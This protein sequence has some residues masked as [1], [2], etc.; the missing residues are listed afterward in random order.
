MS[1]PEKQYHRTMA[2]ELKRAPQEAKEELF[3]NN[4]LDYA[5]MVNGLYVDANPIEENKDH[6]IYAM[7]ALMI[8]ELD[9][10]KSTKSL[11][12]LCSF[13]K[14]SPGEIAAKYVE[15]RY[16]PRIIF[17]A[18]ETN[19]MDP[20]IDLAAALLQ[21]P[22]VDTVIEQYHTI[23]A[24]RYPKLEDEVKDYR[25]C[26]NEGNS[27]EGFR[28][29]LK[30]YGFN[31]I[32]DE[33]MEQLLTAVVL[34]GYEAYTSGI[35]LP[36][37][38]L[39][40]SVTTNKKDSMEDRGRSY[41]LICCLY[42]LLDEKEHGSTSHESVKKIAEEC[43]AENC[44]YGNPVATSLM[45]SGAIKENRYD[46][47]AEEIMESL[48]FEKYYKRRRKK[49]C[50]ILEC[51]DEELE[52]KLYSPGE[53]S[54]SQEEIACLLGLARDYGVQPAVIS[55]AHQRILDETDE[56][57]Q[58]M[59]DSV[60]P[61]YYLVKLETRLGKI[62][63][64][65]GRE[66]FYN[67]TKRDLYNEIGADNLKE[68]I[69]Y[70]SQYAYFDVLM[71]ALN[72]EHAMFYRNFN[73]FPKNTGSSLSIINL[74]QQSERYKEELEEARAAIASL[75]K[76]THHPIPKAKG[77]NE[78][79][80][81]SEL[82]KANNEIDDLNNKNDELQKTIDD[83]NEYIRILEDANS[84][85]TEA[86]VVPATAIDEAILHSI[87]IVFVCGDVDAKCSELRKTFPN[88][89]IIEAATQSVTMKSATDLVVYFTKH[90]S[91]SMYFRVKS[92]YKGIPEYFFN[93]TN[94]EKMK[95]E[96]SAFIKS[97]Q[98]GQGA[99]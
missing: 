60:L 99:E 48:Y 28:H 95:R 51:E 11:D 55:E 15:N 53:N 2:R 62:F 93:G 24:E 67:I 8:M 91:H 33:Y 77:S 27:E 58:M 43:I 75:R 80:F 74:R 73:Y 83:L 35:K 65:G 81:R 64:D 26:L 25:R 30:L 40:R 84:A 44:I 18:I 21:E 90:I 20:Y 78:K 9:W 42:Q 4:F 98:I 6:L 16:S 45:R 12:R 72:K 94:I 47:T 17:S 3:V 39:F 85:E 59:N 97:S 46:M 34:M 5:D 61:M 13:F 86:E 50:E 29:L 71:N 41:P 37:F 23:L 76:K 56:S 87:R 22:Y 7:Q 19:E 38:C 92:S 36:F 68:D 54:N 57:L 31:A 49:L 70:L 10:R 89:T 14:E 32:D 82:V 63:E 88:S 52:E 1:K 66:A 96:V 79:Y 69:Y